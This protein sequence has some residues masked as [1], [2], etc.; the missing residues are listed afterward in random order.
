MYSRTMGPNG[1]FVNYFLV[2]TNETGRADNPINSP[3]Y[4]ESGIIR[5]WHI[6]LFTKITDE[7]WEVV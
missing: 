6:G 7:G 3:A 5:S 2:T 4:L 1:D